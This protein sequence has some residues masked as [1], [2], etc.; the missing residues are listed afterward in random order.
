MTV[1]WQTGARKI[2][3]WLWSILGLGAMLRLATLNRQSLWLDEGFSYWIAR[4]PWMDLVAYLPAHD[5]HPPLYYLVLQPMIALGG[6]EWLLRLPSALAGIASIGMLYLLGVELFDQRTGL[7]A[8]LVLAVSPLHIWYAQEARMYALVAALTLASGLFAVRALRTNRLIDWTLMAICQALALWTNTAAIWFTLA[9]NSAALLTALA[10]WRSRRFWPWVGAQALA[11]AL[12]LPWLPA[13]LQQMQ[14]EP[15]WIPPATLTILT[16]TLADFVGSHERPRAEAGL[17]L[18]LLVTILAAGARGLRREAWARRTDYIWLG[19]WFIVPVGLAFLISQPYVRVPLLSLIF[20]PGRSVFLARN[21]IVATF[22]LYLL[23]A[24]S[25]ALAKRSVLAV[26]LAALVTLNSVA[27]LGN[28]L[29]ERKEDYRAAA[30]IVADH[31]MPNDLIVFAP[32]YLELPFA[33]YHNNQGST[34]VSL[35]E[36]E[37]GVI[38]EDE[39]QIYDSPAAALGNYRRVWLISTSSNEYRQDT[40]GTTAAVETSYRLLRSWQVEEVTVRFYERRL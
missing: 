16:R 38:A 18:L 37:D 29:P 13:F 9:L 30:L 8:A 2:V 35:D 39:R 27:Y 15:T 7:L 22:P 11:I 19:C 23:L 21:L 33:Y 17:A 1:P 5:I 24:R 32:S 6:S 31:A 20:E 36:L 10:L 3:P 34:T 4:R 26:A 25:L 28:A 40:L 12:Y 14:S